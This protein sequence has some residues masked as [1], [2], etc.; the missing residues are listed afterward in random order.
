[1]EI[2]RVPERPIE[3]LWES[4]LGKYLPIVPVLQNIVHKTIFALNPALLS[5]SYTELTHTLSY[6]QEFMYS[7]IG[8]TDDELKEFLTFAYNSISDSYY[9]KKHQKAISSITELI[10][11]SAHVKGMFGVPD[12]YITSFSTITDADQIYGLIYL[13]DHSEDPLKGLELDYKP[14]FKKINKGADLPFLSGLLLIHFKNF[15]KLSDAKEI[16]ERIRIF[17]NSNNGLKK[18]YLINAFMPSLSY[19]NFL[20]DMVKEW[21]HGYTSDAKDYFNMMCLSDI[22]V[23]TELL[24]DDD[25][26][27]FLFDRINHDIFYEFNGG[28]GVLDGINNPFK[29]LVVFKPDEE[30]F[31]GVSSLLIIALLKNEILQLNGEHTEHTDAKMEEENLKVPKTLLRIRTFFESVHRAVSDDNDGV[32]SVISFI[33]SLV[34]YFVHEKLHEKMRTTCVRHFVYSIFKTLKP[35]FFM[36]NVTMICKDILKRLRRVLSS[37]P[38]E[39]H[40]QTYLIVVSLFIEIFDELV[41]ENDETALEIIKIVFELHRNYPNVSEINMIVGDMF[42]VL[43]RRF[44]IVDTPPD[45]VSEDSVQK[46]VFY[47]LPEIIVEYFGSM[48]EMMKNGSNMEAISLGNEYYNSIETLLHIEGD[49]RKVIEGKIL[50]HISESTVLVECL[51]VIV[52]I[53]VYYSEKFANELIEIT[54]NKIC[55][56]KNETIV[57]NELST[58]E[59]IYWLTILCTS[60]A[61]RTNFT[62]YGKTVMFVINHFLDSPK[63]KVKEKAIECGKKICAIGGM[64]FSLPLFKPKFPIVFQSHCELTKDTHV[65]PEIQSDHKFFQEFYNTFV[66]DNFEKLK[67][68][69]EMQDDTLKGKRNDLL[70]V[71]SCLEVFEEAASVLYD[72]REHKAQLPEEFECLRFELESVYERKMNWE[73]VGHIMIAISKRVRTLF[74]DDK[75]IIEKLLKILRTYLRKQSQNYTPSS[76]SFLIHPTKRTFH[77]KFPPIIFYEQAT[78]IL[79]QLQSFVYDLLYTQLDVDLFIEEELLTINI[80]DGD[81][82]QYSNSCNLLRHGQAKEIIEKLMANLPKEITK[83]NINSYI[84]AL[85]ILCTYVNHLEVK[86]IYLLFDVIKHFIQSELNNFAVFRD[87]ALTTL[88]SQIELAVE[89]CNI[90]QIKELPEDFMQLLYKGCNTNPLMHRILSKVV[91]MYLMKRGKVVPVSLIYYSLEQLLMPLPLPKRYGTILRLCIQNFD[92]KRGLFLV[93]KSTDR[94]TYFKEIAKMIRKKTF[95]ITQSELLSQDLKTDDFSEHHNLHLINEFTSKFGEAGL[96]SAVEKSI[97]IPQDIKERLEKFVDDKEKL[98]KYI[99]LLGFIVTNDIVGDEDDEEG[100]YISLNDYLLLHQF[101]QIFGKK[102][103]NLLLDMTEERLSKK[104]KDEFRKAMVLFQI[105]L[106]GNEMLEI[107][108]M[109]EVT[110]RLGQIMDGIL[111][112]QYEDAYAYANRLH[113]MFSCRSDP[114]ITKPFELI[115]MGKRS[116]LSQMYI[117]TASR[118]RFDLL[119]PALVIFEEIVRNPIEQLIECA[120]T[121]GSKCL[122]YQMQYPEEMKNFMEVFEKLVN[123]MPEKRE[124]NNNAIALPPQYKI[125]PKI[126][127]PSYEQSFIIKEDTV[128]LLEKVYVK[129]LSY[130]TSTHGVMDDVAEIFDNYSPLFMEEKSFGVFLEFLLKTI[131]ENACSQNQVGI[132]ARNI[133]VTIYVHEFRMTEEKIRRVLETMFELLVSPLL[134]VRI[135]V[136]DTILAVFDIFH[137]IELICEFIEKLKKKVEEGGNEN[138]QHA[139]ILAVSALIGTYKTD[140]PPFF[141]NILVDFAA[142]PFAVNSCISAKKRAL[143]EFWESRKDMWDV[144]YAPLF[145]TDQRILLKEGSTPQYIV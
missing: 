65:D 84:F 40:F 34:V 103:S 126:L 14:S 81:F 92:K 112:Q 96:F 72:I 27:N 141:V 25:F 26:I 71:L 83:N 15:F 89:T 32:V 13:R 7:G 21:E 98:E 38:D 109:R 54:L 138:Y 47:L 57:I 130:A 108:E 142:M 53:F 10:L 95:C 105:V 9:N 63:D 139:Y 64:V 93:L 56:R 37:K 123:E 107:E 11:S 6:L 61:H 114:R 18:T 115:A 120:I 12:S 90:H 104:N 33:K 125:I 4:Y 79:Y 122:V 143:L 135:I 50:K 49:H 46:G 144:Y 68:L 16:I 31:I 23:N 48:L 113:A 111:S 127:F 133:S 2:E 52:E 101:I 59:K 69:A 119:D 128:N 29:G 87:V 74:L 51:S 110:E 66:Y 77:T 28:D 70:H 85:K 82:H 88:V 121:F 19:D 132:L 36:D 100:K 67:Q 55:E 30:E 137:P 24:P 44:Y 43:S 145:T 1:M 91:S 94:S 62:K 58:N 97:D 42:L 78:S 17:P 136:A 39:H 129:L 99:T 80:C 140:I 75:K 35:M 131:K 60:L 5:K 45:N 118:A 116:V 8:L 3:R 134:Q 22:L 106:E 102:V 124:D 117:L 73:S 76:V 20:N 86:D 41:D